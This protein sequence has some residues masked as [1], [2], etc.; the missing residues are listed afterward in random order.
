MYRRYLLVKL[1][2]MDK[3]LQMVLF[4]FEIPK[5]FGLN[6][7]TRSKVI[8]LLIFIKITRDLI[9]ARHLVHY[10]RRKNM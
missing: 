3:I 2:N 4:Y 7:L 10:S 8:A 9:E 6:S 5:K 1:Y